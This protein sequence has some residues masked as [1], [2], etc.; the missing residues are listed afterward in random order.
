MYCNRCGN[1]LSAGVQFCSACGE[2]VLGVPAGPPVVSGTT[3]DLGAGGRVRRHVGLLAALWMANGILVCWVCFRSRCSD[4]CSCRAF[5]ELACWAR[6]IS[7]AR[8]LAIVDGIYV[9]R[10]SIG[11]V[12]CG[13][14][15]SGVGI[16]RAKA[17][18]T[19]AGIGDR[20]PGIAAFSVGDGI[21]NLR[22]G[23]YYLR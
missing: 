8:L 2:R 20:L 14:S 21:G 11:R 17:V 10:H 6:G 4:T 22:C 5:S 3:M 18:G 23:C 15:N 13:A 16:V 12:R 7:L 19:S 9:G 1:P